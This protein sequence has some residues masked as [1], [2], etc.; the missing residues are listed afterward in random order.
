MGTELEVAG[1]T[2][3]EISELRNLAD[4]AKNYAKF[5]RSHNTNRAYAS[6]WNDFEFWCRSKN[7]SPMP[8]SPYT[9]AVYLT[10]RA[11]YEW[12][13]SKGRQQQP[14]KA[15]SLQ[16]RLTAISQAHALA[17][18]PFDRRHSDIMETW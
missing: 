7:L 4:L 12:T 9:V 16:R 18:K 10:D 3:Y 5:A 13:D 6:D 14:L 11:T 17:K 2:T 15:S 1:S 8:A